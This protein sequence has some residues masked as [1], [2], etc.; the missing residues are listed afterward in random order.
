MSALVGFVLVVLALLSL[1]PTSAPAADWRDVTED[2]LLKAD[3]DG[4][5]WLMYNRTYSG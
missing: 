1:L 4:A 3:G 5:N 2:R